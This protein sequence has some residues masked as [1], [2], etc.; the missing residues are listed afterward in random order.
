MIYKPKAATKSSNSVQTKLLEVSDKLE[1]KADH[2]INAFT[3][4]QLSV[5]PDWLM[6]AK[7]SRLSLWNDL[8]AIVP[9]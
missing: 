1:N 3:V 6:S 8:W 5:Q 2:F 9:L 4:E 7:L